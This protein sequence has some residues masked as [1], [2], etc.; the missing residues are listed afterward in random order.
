MPDIAS[1][2]T[3]PLR[4]AAEVKDRIAFFN[5]H[6]DPVIDGRPIDRPITPWSKR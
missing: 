3:D 2:Y 6:V 4:E 1:T 5:E